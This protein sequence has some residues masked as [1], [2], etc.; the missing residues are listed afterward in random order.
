MTWALEPQAEG[1]V[2]SVTA[3]DVPVGIRAED[4]EVGM[5]SSLSNLAAMIEDVRHLPE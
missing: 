2:L 3:E 1:T 5:A 4:H